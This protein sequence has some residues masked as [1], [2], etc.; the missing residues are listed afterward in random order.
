M[1]RSQKLRMLDFL[2]EY[3]WITNRVCMINLNINNPFQRMKELRSLIQVED[4]FVKSKSGSRF[5]VFYINERKL[6]GYIRRN[7]L[8]VMG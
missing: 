2:R 4:K 6:K 8:E 3:G 1:K 7:N 5:K